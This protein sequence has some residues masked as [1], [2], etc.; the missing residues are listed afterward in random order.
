[1][2]DDKHL[3]VIADTGGTITTPAESPVI[4]TLGVPQAIVAEADTQYEFK[5]WTITSG[6]VTIT[7]DTSIST[8]ATLNSG[9]DGMVQAN[10]SVIPAYSLPDIENLACG[11][12]KT[13]LFVDSSL[14]L[15]TIPSKVCFL[16]IGEFKETC[17]IEAGTLDIQQVD[18]K[19]A[20]DYSAYDEG[21]WYKIING[22]PDKSVEIMFTVVEGSDETF[23]FRGTLSR[24]DTTFDEYYISGS[25]HVRSCSM[26]FVSSLEILK[27]VSVE[28][29]LVECR[30]HRTVADALISFQDIISSMI[31]LGY[32]EAFDNT[33]CVNNSTDFVFTCGAVEN[34]WHELNINI[35]DLITG[36]DFGYFDNTQDY[37][38]YQRFATAYDIL[39][40]I[41]FMFA[42]VPRYQYGDENGI[43][44]ATPSENKS[45]IIFNARGGRSGTITPTGNI[46]ESKI[47]LETILKE[48]NY[49]LSDTYNFGT[50][51]TGW[52]FEDVN[53]S[54]TASLPPNAIFDIDT[55]LDF[56]VGY[57]TTENALR[58]KLPAA[59]FIDGLRY[60]DY[61]I[62]DYVVAGASSFNMFLFSLIQYFVH[63]FSSGRNQVTRT[64]GSIQANDTA[65]DSQR[66]LQT[67]KRHEID[68]GI[69]DPT[70]TYYATEV[71]KNILT[72]R[73]QI[74]WVQE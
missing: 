44:S 50:T 33:L 45:R 56:A 18:V 65:T 15:L 23:L 51:T 11:T 16:E 30:L 36:N 17:D 14:P 5:N 48:T 22:Y 28:D 71:S 57:A 24:Q 46:V 64:Y 74:V 42:V 1:M 43:I 26:K 61:T 38:W 66:W 39:Q 41:C 10:F 4:V 19:A 72:N 32:S 35:G 3:Y 9:T 53:G 31:T 62:N 2:A 8:T 6:D 25:D 49:R 29:L 40:M 52:Y 37:S 68:D 7:D 58:S 70:P 59:N 60:W 20:E 63:R 69:A 34:Y 67:M 27:G 13:Y 73:A 54:N 47:T 55:T 12:V 21:F